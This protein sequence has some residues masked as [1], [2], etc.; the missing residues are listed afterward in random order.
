MSGHDSPLKKIFRANIVRWRKKKF[1]AT[2]IYIILD[3]RL[4]VEVCRFF[5]RPLLWIDLIY[6]NLFF[7]KQLFQTHFTSEFRLPRRSDTSHGMEFPVCKSEFPIK[8]YHWIQ[9]TKI[10]LE[11]EHFL[12]TKL[13]FP[14][15]GTHW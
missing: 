6:Y 7:F 9:L 11:T 3:I 15:F 1:F 4:K 5:S 13:Q 2:M 8:V 14:S 12:K 10:Y